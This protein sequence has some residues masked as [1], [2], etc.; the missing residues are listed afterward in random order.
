MAHKLINVPDQATDMTCL[1]ELHVAF[2]IAMTK[3]GCINNKHSQDQ[4]A[5][6]LQVTL[7]VLKVDSKVCKFSPHLKLLLKLLPLSAL[8]DSS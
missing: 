5:G 2:F 1:L 6:G 3:T 8:K 7:K 4:L